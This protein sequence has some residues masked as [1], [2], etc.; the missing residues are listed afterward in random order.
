VH[1]GNY[2][3]HSFCLGERILDNAHLISITN[4]IDLFSRATLGPVDRLHAFTEAPVKIK[5]RNTG[6]PLDSKW[7]K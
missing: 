2:F 5:P 7:L 3:S 6:I 1:E 4:A